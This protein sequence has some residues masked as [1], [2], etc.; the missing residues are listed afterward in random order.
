MN[1]FKLILPAL[2]FMSF[3]TLTAAESQ[4]K[5]EAKRFF[6]EY[7]KYVKKGGKRSE[8][9]DNLNAALTLHPMNQAYRYAELEL[10]QSTCFSN[11]WNRW[12]KNIHKQLARCKKFHADF[13][14]YHD[15][16]WNKKMVFNS[17]KI[18]GSGYNP[19]FEIYSRH[20]NAPTKIQ[21]Q[22]LIEL[23]NEL[24]P[25]FRMDLKRNFYPYDL[26]DGLNSLTELHNYSNIVWRS[27]FS[28]YYGDYAQFLHER[29]Q[30]YSVLLNHVG[31]FIKQHPQ[32]TNKTDKI[33]DFLGGLEDFSFHN[34][35]IRINDKVIINHLHNSTKLIQQLQSLP[36][37]NARK[38]AI[39][40]KLRQ[41]LIN[42]PRTKTAIAPI[43]DDYFAE[44]YQLTPKTFIGHSPY[45]TYY[46]TF[47]QWWVKG[48]LNVIKTRYKL[49]RKN[50]NLVTTSEKITKLCRQ[51]NW[52]A[53]LTYVDEMRNRNNQLIK[54]RK[55]VNYYQN[56][57]NNFGE[58]KV[59]DNPD[60]LK[61]FTL[62]NHDFNIQIHN[63]QKMFAYK[64]PLFVRG[65]LK[66]KHIIYLLMQ[67]KVNNKMLLGIWDL[68][69]SSVKL[70]QTPVDPYKFAGVTQAYMPIPA[71]APW[72]VG[73]DKVVIV[74][75]NGDVA[76]LS[77]NNQQWQ[78]ISD[79]IPPSPRGVAIVGNKIFVLCGTGRKKYDNSLI[80]F[81]FSGKDYM[82]NFSNARSDKQHAI[83]N[84]SGTVNSLIAL[85]DNELAFL[86]STNGTGAVFRYRLATGKF[87]RIC[88]LPVSSYEDRLYYQNNKL[89]CLTDGHGSRI[90]SI[91]PADGKFSCIMIQYNFR[92][93]ISPEDRPLQLK[94]N[95]DLKGPFLFNKDFL[96]CSY[97][98]P[99]AVNWKHPRQSPQLF[100]PG[101]PFLTQG[102][103]SNSV[104][105]FSF[106]HC[107]VV[108]SRF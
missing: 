42:A 15:S 57:A 75:N 12:I 84:L 80:S 91:N 52:K 103:T 53:L 26:S 3:F 1:K 47:I 66:Y 89:Y 70:L 22:Q 93:K 77:L 24:R 32:Q 17:H 9:A 50:R 48:G 7:E 85:N 72:T 83:E 100:L 60:A 6:E 25:L 13:P 92:Y 96:W 88:T 23:C 86:I 102:A 55:V 21:K 18:F 34:G 98:Y 106:S 108:K 54:Q 56:L 27:N 64:Y 41:R 79:L 97:Y 105:Y 37:V 94:T 39:Q 30:A 14:Q 43:I 49:F 104:I 38:A 82:I 45:I 74:C 95:W 28:L 65:V 40:L 107:F 16:D 81:D 68:Q 59:P 63:Y 31:Q 67:E 62:M 78:T 71:C 2:L 69:N 8:V 61:F 4:S 58:Q 87:K 5:T 76:I 29:A 46:D 36:L 44:L 19:F 10:Y 35:S 101:S 20:R 33:L 99:A 51:C 11:D 90:Y 73:G